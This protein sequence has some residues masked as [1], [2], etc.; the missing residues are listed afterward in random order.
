V[1]SSWAQA[2]ESSQSG[3]D[4]FL[5]AEQM[6]PSEEKENPLFAELQRHLM[7]RSGEELI[8]QLNFSLTIQKLE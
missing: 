5:V 3:D 8:P 6:T 7:G 4:Q 2:D 1:S